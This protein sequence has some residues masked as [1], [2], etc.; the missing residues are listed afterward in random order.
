MTIR[1]TDAD[2]L[3][4]QDKVIVSYRFTLAQMEDNPFELTVHADSGVGILTNTRPLD[5]ERGCFTS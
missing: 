2:S 3:N 1:T 4:S 5:L